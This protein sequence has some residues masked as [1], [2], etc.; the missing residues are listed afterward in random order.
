MKEELIRQITEEVL[1]QIG[2]AGEC[3]CLPEDKGKKLL[4]VGCPVSVPEEL[5]KGYVVCDMNDF[6]EH[7][8]AAQYERIVIT[9]LSLTDLSDIAQGRD[10]S[11]AS[12]AVVEGLLN[13]IDVYLL[14]KA[15]PHRR[16]AGK[17][18][19]RL[20]E[21]IENHV[22]ALQTYGVRMIPELRPSL[23]RKPVPPKYQAPVL[24]VP[25]GSARPNSER[26]ITEEL[27]RELTADGRREVCIEENAI[28]TP[29]AWDVFV[30]NKIKVIRE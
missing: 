3:G 30:H 21:V 15:L 11:D 14:E 27:A 16:F 23:P 6:A 1:R 7:R 28:I 4:A 2:M 13:G 5:Q 29:L 17:G 9:D 8:S 22:R 10:A 25:A 19:S 24:R 26:L 18:S 12:C 20:Y